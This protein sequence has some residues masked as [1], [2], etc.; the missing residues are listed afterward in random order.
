[1]IS[2]AR[3]AELA[4]E[5]ARR[6]EA[7]LKD[8]LIVVPGAPPRGRRKFIAGR[9]SPLGECVNWQDDPPRCVLAVPALDLLAWLAARGLVRVEVREAAK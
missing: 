9:G 1:V 3:A 2:R 5:C 7:G 4:A 8:V 6:I